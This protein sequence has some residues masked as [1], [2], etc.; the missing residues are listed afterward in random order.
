M[1]DYWRNA[2]DR[3]DSPETVPVIPDLD[4]LP[5]EYVREHCHFGTQPVPEPGDWSELVRTMEIMHGEETLL[6]CSD[7]PPLGH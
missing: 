2:R 1:D 7:Y 4:A 3:A 6:Y 5:S